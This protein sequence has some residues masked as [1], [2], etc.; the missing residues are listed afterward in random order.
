MQSIK[1]LTD[2]SLSM[3]CMSCLYICLYEQFEVLQTTR[4]LRAVHALRAVPIGY[5]MW[6]L[7]I[8][9]KMIGKQIAEVS[10]E[11]TRREIA[12]SRNR[13]FVKT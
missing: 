12:K 11:L 1:Q 4:R 7:S 13:F 9:I 5:L 6:F 10:L 3:G 8:L 2:A